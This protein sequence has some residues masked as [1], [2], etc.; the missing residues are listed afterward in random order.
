MDLGREYIIKQTYRPSTRIAHYYDWAIWVESGSKSID[1]IEEVEYLLHSSFPE[2]LR[3]CKDPAGNFRL[4]AS[5]WGEFSIRILIREKDGQML[6]TSHWLDLSSENPDAPAP[7]K[8]QHRDPEPG[9]RLKSVFLSF[10]NSQTRLAMDVAKQLY[11]IGLEVKS[12]VQTEP[13]KSIKENIEEAIKSSDVVITIKSGRKA[14]KW[15]EL[16]EQYAREKN[17]TIIPLKEL[18]LNR[19]EPDLDYTSKLKSVA[20]KLKKYK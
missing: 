6:R 8:K 13:G 17:K 10:D 16:E 11:D 18:G 9:S 14:G 20:D 4:H 15:Q 12:S 19:I 7:V 2:P 5:G 3:V 1:N